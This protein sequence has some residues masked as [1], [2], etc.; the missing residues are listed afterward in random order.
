[1]PQ[2]PI[3]GDATDDSNRKRASPYTNI[4][5]NKSIT[6]TMEKSISLILYLQSTLEQ[7]YRSALVKSAK[8]L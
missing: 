3:A 8:P 2:C 7:K 5:G 6:A 1:V 4:C